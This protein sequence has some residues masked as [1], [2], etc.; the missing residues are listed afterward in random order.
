MESCVQSCSWQHIPVC[1]AYNVER[2]IVTVNIQRAHDSITNYSEICWTKIA[3]RFN[4]Y[5]F[6]MKEHSTTSPT[7]NDNMVFTLG[8]VAAIACCVHSADNLE[9]SH[10]FEPVS[11]IDGHNIKCIV[12]NY[13]QSFEKIRSEI[14]CSALCLEHRG[15]AYNYFGNSKRC[16]VFLGMPTNFLGVETDAG[17][18]GCVSKKAR[19]VHNFIPYTQKLSYW[20]SQ[21]SHRA[22]T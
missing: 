18:E 3:R 10:K 16:Q 8:L 13:D 22:H 9:L 2:T 19:T 6:A 15:V 12:G 14:V 5:T 4:T 21:W 1:G 11:N 20:R 17:L 7:F